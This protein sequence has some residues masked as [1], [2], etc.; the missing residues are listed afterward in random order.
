M[1]VVEAG[2]KEYLGILGLSFQVKLLGELLV[3]NNINKDTNNYFF[4]EVIELLH[5]TYFETLDM[6][7]IMTMIKEYYQKYKIPPNIDN[8]QTMITTTIQNDVEKQELEARLLSI[9]VIWADIKSGKINNDRQFTK[10]KTLTFIKQQEFLLVS[11]ECDQKLSYGI[12]DADVIFTITEKFKKVADIGS[13]INYGID[14]FDN[15]DSLLIEDY[16]KPIGTGIK[17]VDKQIGGGLSEGEWALIM[18]GSGIGKTPFLTVIANNAYQHG[19]NSLH[20]I[21]EGKAD[22]VRRAHYSKIF[23]TPINDLYKNTDAIKKKMAELKTDARLGTLRVERLPDDTTPNKLRK[24]IKRTEDKL[25]YKFD[26]ICLDY[27]DCLMPNEK[28]QDKW[29]GQETVARN[30]ESMCEEEGWRMFVGIQAKKEAGSKRILEMADCGGSVERLKKAQLVMFLGADPE[31]KTKD[32]INLGVLKCRFARSG[33][34]WEK[35]IFNN[36]LLSFSV[37][38]DAAAVAFSSEAPIDQSRIQETNEKVTSN[39][40]NL[41]KIPENV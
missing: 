27:I 36:S 40:E 41:T 19:H 29:F 38:K 12:V 16:R 14:I 15:P 35:C 39:R 2:K 21:M 28:T 18:A 6:R 1:E 23:K 10:S 7:R 11:K 22:N 4:D 20:I 9:K 13:P 33:Y 31:E 8:I 3:P 34:L 37:P 32:Q 24:W 5:P 26:M 17:E 30:I 25:G